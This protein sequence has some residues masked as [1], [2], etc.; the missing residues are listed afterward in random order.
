MS[1]YP[2]RPIQ[3]KG[4]KRTKKETSRAKRQHTKAEDEHL[5]RVVSLGCALCRHKGIPD[6]PAE[7][8][9]IRTGVGAGRRS[10]HFDAIPL[11]PHYHRI[12]PEALHVVGRKAWE[13]LHS[14]TEMQL[15]TM[16]KDLLK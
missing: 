9:H 11:A 3:P 15:L 10:S 8:H 7:V 4:A 1:Q 12:G 5:D 13:R 6:V 2:S 14:I 16:T